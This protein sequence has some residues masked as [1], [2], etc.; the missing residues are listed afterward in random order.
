MTRRSIDMVRLL[1]MLQTIAE[2]KI[3][4]YC[5]RNF[6]QETRYLV[7][8]MRNLKLPDDEH[9][10]RVKKADIKTELKIRYKLQMNPDYEGD[11]F[12]LKEEDIMGNDELS[13]LIRG[14]LEDRRRDWHYYDYDERASLMYMATRLAPNYAC[15]RTVM[16]EIHDID[17]SFKPK[18]VLDFG[19]GMGTTIW[20]VNDTWPDTVS[21][22]MNVEIS[23]EQQYLC[24]YLLRGGK[25][26]GDPLPGV[27]HRQYLPSSN[28]VK[29]DLVVVAFSMLELPNSELRANTIENLWHKTND[30]LVVVER[31]NRGGFA[32][33][34]EARHFI[35]D[36]SGHD[37]TKKI[38]L[39]PESRPIQKQK[40]PEAH[41]FAPCPH[42]FACPRAMM[43]NKKNMDICRFKVHFEPLDIGERKTGYLSE[44]FS[45][46]VL[47]KRPHPSYLTNE[48]SMRLPRIVEKRKHSKKKF[49]HKLCCP[50][51]NLAETVITQK[52]YGKP[53][54]ELAKS[55]DWGDLF[56]VKIKDTY[57]SR[58]S[59]LI[60][61]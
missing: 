33:I 51:G 9:S 46:V 19:S 58:N 11:E 15:L 20:A 54:F 48:C 3:R 38:N 24:E 36:M 29:Y 41:V 26:F 59:K 27:F 47:R 25:E 1:A 40:I 5:D 45:Y 13:Q 39:T 32:T 34:N 50:N 4:N 7:N 17:P 56:P 6:R 52:K 23:K 60:K 10:I 37:V 57:F 55:C 18:S 42:E 8:F 12:K 44:E 2:S 35:L 53:A 16:K 14:T 61:G 31:G 22:F 21:E 30:L 43:T 28:K 49:T